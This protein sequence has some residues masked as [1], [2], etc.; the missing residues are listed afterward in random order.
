MEGKG[1]A[2][3]ALLIGVVIGANQK[4]LRAYLSKTFGD[5]GS[6]FGNFGEN[7]GPKLG[8]ALATVGEA[9][10]SGV[11]STG[12]FFK[13]AYEQTLHLVPGEKGNHAP[14]AR[15]RKRVAVGARA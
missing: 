1:W 8:G 9:A 14:R 5:L 12:D 15:A 4:K 13:G 7:L 3:M 2:V 10:S 6:S 11:K